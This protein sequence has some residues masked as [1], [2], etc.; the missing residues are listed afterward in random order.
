[1]NSFYN[2]K[3][4]F[5]LN[6]PQKEAVKT[7]EGPLLVLSGAGTGKTRVLTAR[8]ANL[9]YS[10][11]TK[12]WNILAVTFTNK[13]AKEMKHRLE[14][15][16]GP[17]ANSLWLGTF[18]SI[19]A[20]ILRENAAIVGLN[21]N[22]TIITPDD[23]VRLLKQI[24]VDENVDIKK[25]TPKVMSGLIGSW[26]DKGYKPENVNNLNN[27]FFA[28]GKAINIY[29]I[30]QLRLITLNCT[31]FGDLLMHN[32]T[33]FNEH[34]DILKKY[35]EKILYFLV[36]EYQD[37]N[38][39]QYLWLRLLAE[40]TKNICCVG[41]DDQSIYG[42]RGAQVG[43]ILRFEKD[44]PSAKT[45]KLE[46]NYRSTGRILA[47]AN[48]VISNNKE[49]LGKNL[50]TSS[51]D[52]DKI[53]LIAVWDGIEEK[54]KT[55]FEIENLSSLGYRH[56]QMA[57][58]VRAGH[59]TRYFEERFIEIGIPYKVVGAKFYERL[60]IRDTLAYLRVIQQPN[61]DLALER[62]INTPKRG[63]GLSTTKMI[64]AYARKNEI[65]FFSASEELL[66]TDEFRPN[67]K[68]TLQSLINQFLGWRKDSLEITHTELAMK[69]LEESGYILYW[70]NDKSIE[71][72]GRL[73]NL[74]ELVNAMSG[75]E[76]LAGFLEHISLV[77]DGDTQAEAG[78]VSLMT[79]HAAK[80]LEFDAVFLPGWEEGLFPSQRSIDELGLI[81]L[82]EERRLAYV[83]ITRARKRLF[84][85]YAANRQIHGLWQGSIPS[86]F[87]GELPKQNLN[88][89]IEGNL[90]AVA[91]SYNQ[92][93]FED[94]PKNNS[95]GPG[96]F[97]AKQNKID[98]INQY[99]I[100][101]N[102]KN[103]LKVMNDYK[104]GQRVFHQK[105]G[106]G[107]I[108]SSEGDKLNIDFDKAGE[109]KVISSYI[110]FVD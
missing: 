37:T 57:V 16:I 36:D 43:N 110:K 74:K 46:E 99:S 44:Y 8:L 102:Q 31:D 109:K 25:F 76:N 91:S 10:N 52:G 86:R 29:K 103:V 67:V 55:G 38:T 82:E 94:I 14:A 87:I 60:E 92:F 41:D 105:F 64:H 73:E 65:S 20:K 107:T 71:N 66:T 40:K 19:A 49:R 88:E 90:G 45:I 39:T 48:S 98:G 104:K 75:F 77:M 68:R 62:I 81:G 21:S 108:I 1:M 79:L 24:M 35:H 2:H 3:A 83:G 95:Y 7:L 15:L 9:L 13:A 47:A 32:L 4:F 63:L 100:S 34:P 18:H 89:N 80:G 70:Q 96:F 17:S 50:R 5:D 72:E 33:I 61:D 26:K 22:Y 69:V 12:P 84:I 101:K 42:W 54:R 56:D 30:Y 78:E 27:D 53:E 23:Q 59:Q 11:V 58:L 85:T 6:E 106:M 28:N 97:R 51:A 93:E